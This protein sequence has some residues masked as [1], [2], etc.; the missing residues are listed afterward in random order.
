[1]KFTSKQ[2]KGDGIGSRHVVPTINLLVPK[3]FRVE[4]GV[5]ACYCKIDKVKYE[6]ALHFG[7]RPTFDKRQ[8]SL[9]LHIL[10]QKIYPYDVNQNIEVD[11]VKWI[12]PNMIFKSPQ[13]LKRQIGEDIQKINDVFKNL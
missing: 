10:A 1:M 4:P 11:I 8:Y 5:Y 13:D 2:I 3:T 12:R 7:P 9:E 6:G